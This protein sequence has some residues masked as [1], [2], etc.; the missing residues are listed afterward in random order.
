MP[1]IAPSRITSIL[2]VGGLETRA[3]YHNDRIDPEILMEPIEW[4]PV[5]QKI[6]DKT[7]S[8]K[9]WLN[10]ALKECEKDL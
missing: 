3:V 10:N 1:K 7:E 4:E 9:Q 8:S 5:N 6:K 2:K